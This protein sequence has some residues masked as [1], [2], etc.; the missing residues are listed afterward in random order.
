MRPVHL[1]MCATISQIHLINGYDADETITVL[2]NSVGP[3]TFRVVGGATLDKGNDIG[4][5]E[6]LDGFALCTRFRLKIM[7][8][9]GTCSTLCSFNLKFKWLSFAFLFKLSMSKI[10]HNMLKLLSNLAPV[11]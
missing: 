10:C 7:G 9:Q 11:S 4:T 3:E 1:L 5:S 6:T 2:E 8:S